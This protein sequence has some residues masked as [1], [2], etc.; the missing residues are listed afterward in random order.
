VKRKKENNICERIE[1]AYYEKIKSNG[2][3]LKQHCCFPNLQKTFEQ[4]KEK[5]SET[6]LGMTTK[7][8]PVVT[9]PNQTQF[10]GFSSF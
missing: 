4:K 10:D 9:R 7:L 1:W 5:P 8:I 2:P 6:E 3:F